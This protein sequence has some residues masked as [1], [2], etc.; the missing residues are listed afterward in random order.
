MISMCSKA[1]VNSLNPVAPLVGMLGASIPCF[2]LDV[3]RYP[4]CS[5]VQFP[6]QHTT[7]RNTNNLDLTLANNVCGSKTLPLVKLCTK[8]YQKIFYILCIICFP[9]LNVSI[10]QRN[11]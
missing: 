9:F 3:A 1:E 10:K 2:G 5:L 7:R 6:L 4:V 11:H 8:G